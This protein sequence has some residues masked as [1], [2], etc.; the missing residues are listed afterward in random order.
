MRAYTKLTAN[1][2]PLVQRGGVLVQSSCSSRVSLDEF[3]AT[4][5]AAIR[6]TGRAIRSLE[7]TGHA[8]DHPIGFPEGAYLKTAFVTLN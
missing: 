5:T 2:V 4:V 7:L 6:R 3:E 1:A 8:I